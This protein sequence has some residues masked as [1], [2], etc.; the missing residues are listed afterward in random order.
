MNTIWQIGSFTFLGAGYHAQIPSFCAEE[1]KKCQV[2]RINLSR[3]HV[4]QA[5]SVAVSQGHALKRVSDLTVTAS[6]LEFKIQA[7]KNN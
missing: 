6:P 1:R 4:A 2:L 3:H 7:S 5:K